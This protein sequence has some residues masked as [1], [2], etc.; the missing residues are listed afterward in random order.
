MEIDAPREKQQITFER[1]T[2]YRAPFTE[3]SQPIKYRVEYYYDNGKPYRWIEL[4][5]LG[6]VETDYF[7]EYDENWIQIGAKY[8]EEGDPEFSSEL[9]RYKNDSTKITEW[10]DSIGKVYYTMIDDLNKDKKT[11]RA[12]FIGDKLHGYDS[13]FYND[14]GFVR[15]IFFTNVKGKVFN[16]RSFVYDSINQNGDWVERKKIMNDTIVEIQRREV[17]Y[18]TSFTSKTNV[19]Y[20]GILSTG[21]LSENVISFSSNDSLVFFTRTED[22]DNQKGFLS[23]KKNGVYQLPIELKELGTLYNGAVSPSGK[24]ILFCS[25]GDKGMQLW[26]TKNENGKWSDKIKI[27]LPNQYEIGYFYWTTETE[28]YFYQEV[29]DGDLFYGNIEG[30][31][32]IIQKS[33]DNINTS[34]ATE[35]SPYVDPE[36]RFLIFTRYQEGNKAN[37][38]F[39]ISYNEGDATE[40]IWQKASKIEGIP[41]GWSLQII[42]NGK[43]FVF[44]NGE[45]FLSYP[46]DKLNLKLN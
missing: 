17:F 37:Q 33:L 34:E 27:E 43:Q 2:Y 41:Y 4:D 8:R 26:L 1:I 16:D 35:F 24:Q 30:N 45:D 11:Y 31:Q 25:K 7:V 3:Q 39:F 15:R 5:S 36:K 42:N 28:L 14:D 10:T 32:L 46:V 23:A 6:K 9:V 13:T 40:P 38:G 19:F 12:A 22:W 44:T 29:N 21:E 20:Q 18:N